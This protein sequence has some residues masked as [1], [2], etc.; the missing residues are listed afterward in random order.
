MR[1]LHLTAG[2]GGMYC[3]TCLRDNTVAAELMAR[4]HDVSLLPVYTPTSTHERNA[5]NGHG[6]FGGSSVFLRQRVPRFRKTPAVLDF[7]CDV[8]AVIKAA[9][10]KGVS[11]DPKDLGELTV[12]ML[13]GQ[14][15]FQAKEIDKVI[16][17]LKTVPLF[18]VVILPVSLLI[19]LAGPLKG[20]LQ[21]PL[22]CMLQGEDL[23]LDFLSAEHRSMATDL[24][25]AHAPQ[26]DAFMATSDYYSDYMAGYLGI[27]RK[28]IHTVPIGIH[29]EG[30]DPSPKPRKDPVTIG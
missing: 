19:G 13:R 22:V 8:P 18:D 28:T 2:A 3:G 29:L 26:V 17:Y 1:L 27:D 10:G 4:S 24:I 21:R 15:G 9:T 16:S 7:L 23:F 11:V 30:H 20:A 6:F 12:S 25:K 14:A 5:S